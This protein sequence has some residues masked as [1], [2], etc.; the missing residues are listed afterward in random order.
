MYRVFTE[1]VRRLVESPESVDA[2]ALA[3]V[4]GALRGCLQAEMRRRGLLRGSPA[5][6]GLH[7][8]HR[9]NDEALEELTS[10][11]YAFV[12]VSRLRSLGAHLRIKPNVDGLVFLAMR[13]FLHER[14]RAHDPL[15]FRIFQG[16]R[17]ATRQA[18]AEGDLRVMGDPEI[19]KN[20]VL[21][22]A[23][24]RA[25]REG[26]LAAVMARWD[27][28]PVQ[29]TGWTAG[30]IRHLER[31]LGPQDTGEV[32]FRDLVQAVKED[33]RARWATLAQQSAG[34]TAHEGSAGVSLLV[35]LVHPAPDVEATDAFDKLTA[36]VGR[37]VEGLP[38]DER[39]RGY[40]AAL[41]A[42]L[43]AYATGAAD[44]DAARD[45]LSNRE[46]ADRTGIPRRRLPGLY[47]TLGRL[48]SECR[49]AQSAPRAVTSSRD[50]R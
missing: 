42:Y 21:A 25:G 34:E 14:Q 22:P 31:L 33:A 8:F 39:T 15:G 40:L 3:Q 50:T 45:R 16:I 13:Q 6:L 11:C 36:A 2:P 26:V 20:S 4:W 9:W 29:G 19:G 37:A 7:G 46:L 23:N 24:G 43:I 30:V 35:R 10:D 12:F 47:T 5:W 32:R 1:H 17:A 44:P 27:E 18:V 28:E 48:V 38:A 49:A 41:W